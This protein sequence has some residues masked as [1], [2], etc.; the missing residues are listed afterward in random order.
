MKVNAGIIA[1][2]LVI[3]LFPPLAGGIN[4]S[5]G[6]ETL[7]VDKLYFPGDVVVIKSNFLPDKAYIADPTGKMYDLQFKEENGTY[8]AKFYLD[9]GIVLGNYTVVANNATAEFVVDSWLIAAEYSNGKVSGSVRYF[10]VKPDFIEYTIKPDGVSGRLEIKNGSFEI[11]VELGEYEIVLKCGNAIKEVEVSPELTIAVDNVLTENGTAVI[12]GRVLLDGYPAKANLTYWLEGGKIRQEEINGAFNLS[13]SKLTGV[14]HIRAEAFGLVAERTVEVEALEKVV[15]IKKVYFANDAIF[16]NANF[17]PK[18]AFLINPVGKKITLKF[19]DEN[20]TYVAK[21]YLDKGI[22][23]GNYTVY[24]DGIV[25]QFMVDFCEISAKFDGDA[26]EGQARCYFTKPEAVKYTIMGKNFS[27]EGFAELMAGNFSIPLHAPPGDYTALLEC[28]NAK[29]KVNF[30]LVKAEEKISAKDFYFL[31]E[32]VLINSTFIPSEAYVVTPSNRTVEL[33]F[34][35]QGKFYVAKLLAEEVGR[36]ELHVDG[37]NLSFFVDDYSIKASY[38]GSAIVGEVKWHFV[39]PEFVYYT[40]GKERGRVEVDEEGSFV[41]P[42]KATE[43][44]M[45]ECGNAVKRIDTGKPK[46][47]RKE[48]IAFD[49]V[50]KVIVIKKHQKD[51]EARFQ[52]KTVKKLIKQLIEEEIPATEENLKKFNLSLDVLNTKIQS[53]RIKEDLIRVE[54]SNKLETWYRFSVKIPEGYR[55]KEIVGDDGR[56]IVNTVHINRTTGEVE[57]DL[58]WYIE[59]GTLYFYDD[60]IY[61][62]NIS[63]TP[64][65]PNRSIAIE[66]AYSGA[67][68]GA[69]QISAIVFPYS[70]GDSPATIATYDHAGRTGDGGYGY[71]IDMDAG[72]KIAIKFQSGNRARQFG[73]PY[74]GGNLGNAQI[75]HISRDD[76]LLNTVPGGELE[77]VI[78]TDMQTPAWRRVQLN[79][80]QKVIIRDNNRWFAT[81][82]YVENIGARTATNLRFFQGMDWNF[83]G[84]YW[85]DDAYYDSNNDT[86]YGYDSNAPAGDIQYGG[87]SSNLPSSQHDVGWYYTIWN[88]IAA[89]NLRNTN[90]YIGDAGTA[91]AWDFPS[92]APGEKIVIPIIWGLGYDHDDMINQIN[93][94]KSKLFDAGILS[95]DAPANNSKYNPSTAGVV[96]F[97]ATAALFGLVD[98]ENLEVV[99]NVTR[100]GGGWSY[101]NTTYVNL[102]VPYAETSTVSFPLNLSSL[103][104]GKYKAEFRTNLPNDQNSTNDVKWIYFYIVAFTVEPDQQKTANPGSEVYY[105]FT[106]ANYFAAGRFDVSITSSTKGWA[107]RLYNGSNLI[108]EDSDGDG[109]WD[110]INEDSN[111][112]GVPDIFLPYGIGYVN[113]SKVIPSTA[114][115]GETDTTTLNFSSISSP[116]INDDVRMSTST[117]QPPTEQKQFYLHP[118]SVMNTSKAV[119]GITAVEASTIESWYQSPPFASTFRIYGRVFVNLWMNSSAAATNQVAVSV[120]K[121]DGVSSEVIGTNVSQ[122]TMT[123]SPNLYTLTIPLT[124]PIT[125]NRGEYVILRIDNPS[126]NDI[127]VFQS[128][129]YDSNI[130]LNTTTY[131]KVAT[132]YSSECLS[133]EPVRIYT[134]VTDPIGSYDISSA[135]IRIYFENGSL[136]ESGVMNMNTTDPSSPSFWKLFDYSTV[137]SQGNYTVNVTAVESNGVN[138]TASLKLSCSVPITPR[139]VTATLSMNSSMIKLDIYA[140]EDVSGIRVYWIKPGNLSITSMT[141]DFDVNGTS[142]S[143]YWW[144]F[145]NIAAGTT[146]HVYITVS[147]TGDFSM[148][149]A[150]NIGVDPITANHERNITN[151]G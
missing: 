61:G 51:E 76:I 8:V 39:K 140:A 143:V 145:N 9:K 36:Y 146:K 67:N 138:Y 102:Y 60:P 16:I 79:I 100:V 72:S 15:E 28:G 114:P 26:I 34:S 105:N 12:E 47:E 134:N 144:E 33:N 129:T 131:V 54:V 103:P 29:Q 11:P 52:I 106:S 58:R 87:F 59:N 75:N 128:T 57:G 132:V 56:R 130:T 45:V 14:L 91:L 113:V 30:S 42:V 101:Q 92:L 97:N 62:Y 104:Y 3:I 82:Y 17:K 2:I 119:Q 18:K 32:T 43:T 44:V 55:I 70:A 122:L 136:A 38:N 118:D 20:G 86:I 31:N 24:V 112:N 6:N 46:T 123:T 133:G 23:L 116:D 141:G 22:V 90:S 99:F 66:L 139:N 4:N 149:Q 110:T 37:L 48:I 73:N 25:K 111:G 120:I 84:S 5:L 108:A 151:S 65:Q 64:P 68:A 94:G 19:K 147:G 50:K 127:F 35:R 7:M 10:Y 21:F 117:P 89:D 1:I 150:F 49:P 85:N 137:L 27:D 109:V 53:K 88:R 142:G 81:V 107:T 40:A 71:N 41:I 83:R 135:T 69:G 121:T 148:L 126:T 115:L 93:D 78:V 96:Y 124:S 80:T 95:I 125:F 74:S 13:F 98:A 77:S 63:L